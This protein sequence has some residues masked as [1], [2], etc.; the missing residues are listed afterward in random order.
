MSKFLLDKYKDLVP[1]TPGE[2]PKDQQY[3]KLNTNESPFSPC[4]AVMKAIENEVPTL[5]LYSDPECKKLRCKLAEIYN[6]NEN[7]IMIGSGSDELLNYVIMA[8]AKELVFPDITYGFY[9]VF[10][11]VNKVPYTT[12][13]LEED[14]TI[15][16]AKYV[17]PGKM[18][19]I[20]NPNA[21]TGIALS[22]EKVEQIIKNNPTSIV[23]I[24]EAYVDFGGESAVPL[25][26]KYSN[27]VVTQ[28]FSKSRFMAG[29]RLGFVIANEEL[30]KDLNTLRYSIS[31]Y[32]VN[33]MTLA[34]GIATLENEDYTKSKCLE[35]IK[36]REY[37]SKS[38]KNIG[39]DVIPS[40]TNFIFAKT[41]KIEG[42][43]LYLTL[44][45]KGILVR[46]FKSERIK[47]YV[48][49]TIGLKENMDALVKAIKEII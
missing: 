24:D 39:F 4:E 32:N 35:I 2:Q 36:N 18:I 30:I 15:D 38:L 43:K 37:L 47:D 16:V 12:I 26:K 3:I 44:K 28:T 48:R 45:E 13:P 7:E 1:Y 33:S 11:D 40:S 19:V 29:A 23:M 5:K 41:D 42:E 22:L 14:F 9:K 8:F 6:V 25:V 21:P 31:P 46:H 27:L 10:A 17:A 20:A 34:A 49:I